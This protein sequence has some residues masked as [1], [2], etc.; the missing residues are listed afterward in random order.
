MFSMSYDA[1]LNSLIFKSDHLVEWTQK[2]NPIAY[3]ETEKCKIKNVWPRICGCYGNWTEVLSN[4]NWRYKT[5]SGQEGISE[6]P[7]IFSSFSNDLMLA[8]LG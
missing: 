5:I 7:G 6:F 3:C 1:V 2:A 8:R 4:C